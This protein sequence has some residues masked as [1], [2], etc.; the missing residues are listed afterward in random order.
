MVNKPISMS[1]VE[2][3]KNYRLDTREKTNVSGLYESARQSIV[4]DYPNS[5]IKEAVLRYFKAC[6]SKSN[7]ECNYEMCL[8]LLEGLCDRGKDD[9]LGELAKYFNEFV[10]PYIPD[11]AKFSTDLGKYK[12]NDT[13]IEMM[14]ESAKEYTLCDRV[15][16]NHEKI[17]KR[18]KLD[19]LFEKKCIDLEDITFL[20]CEMV[21]TYTMKPHAKMEIVIEEMIYQCDRFDVKYNEQKLV[22]SVTDYFLSR[23]ENTFEDINFHYKRILEKCEFISESACDKVKYVTEGEGSSIDD[24]PLS[25]LESTSSESEIQSLMNKYKM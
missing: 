19:S 21:D 9:L 1:I 25:I 13:N 11:M 20:V 5:E 12:I 10:I 23:E 24:N 8:S 17:S 6:S 15:L 14:K 22:E 18:F 4:Y 16:N 2:K 7:I 3:R